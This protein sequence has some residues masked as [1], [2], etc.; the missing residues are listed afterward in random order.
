MYW[1]KAF[2]LSLAKPAHLGQ[3]TNFFPQSNRQQLHRC[4]QKAQ[5][6]TDTQSLVSVFQQCNVVPFKNK[7]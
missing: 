7:S 3:G 6:C 4:P 5:V 1:D 2:T